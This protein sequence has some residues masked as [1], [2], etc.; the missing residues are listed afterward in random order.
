MKYA[1][2]GYP[3]EFVEAFKYKIDKEPEWFL[4]EINDRPEILEY[5]NEGEIIFN[6]AGIIGWGKEENFLKMYKPIE[7]E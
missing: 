2:K 1:I 7:N 5:F 4:I 3:T 6:M